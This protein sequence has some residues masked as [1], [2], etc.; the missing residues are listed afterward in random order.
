MNSGIYQL[1]LVINGLVK[2]SDASHQTIAASD[3]VYFH[4]LPAPIHPYAMDNFHAAH[5]SSD[6]DPLA[7][8]VPGGHLVKR[9]LFGFRQFI[10]TDHPQPGRMNIWNKHARI[11][12]SCDI[13]NM[14]NMKKQSFLIMYV[15]DETS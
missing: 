11:T 12:D 7:R 14:A 3:D 1:F 5:N 8:S 9:N 2:I 15:N 10:F 13:Y 6:L 4:L